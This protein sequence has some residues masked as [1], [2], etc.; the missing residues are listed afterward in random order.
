MEQIKMG[1]RISSLRHNSGLTQKDLAERMNITDKAVSKWERNLCY[2]DIT[3]LTQLADIFDTSVDFLLNGKDAAIQNNK[4]NIID[5]ESIVSIDID[6]ANKKFFLH[7]IFQSAG[8]VKGQWSLNAKHIAAAILSMSLLISIFV[9]VLCNYV[10]QRTLD[11]SWYVVGGGIVLLCITLPIIYC[12]KHKILISWAI[13]S[14]LTIPYLLLIESVCPIKGWVIPLGVPLTVI[15]SIFLLLCIYL[16]FYS[17]INIW[18]SLAIILICSA[19]VSLGIN[20]MVAQYL[21]EIFWHGEKMLDTLINVGVNLTA[22]LTVLIVGLFR[23][24]NDKV[25]DKNKVELT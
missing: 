5:T 25:R 7:N 14:V 13:L 2:P 12:R 24:S 6:K 11:W 15:G 23:R 22:G 19:V 16:F 17:K 10:I 8:F 1:E 18:F 20:F 3:I 4:I 9:C 21:N